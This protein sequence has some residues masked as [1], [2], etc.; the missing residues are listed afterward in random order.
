MLASSCDAS[1][2]S[3][4]SIRQLSI[5]PVQDM[6]LELAILVVASFAAKNYASLFQLYDG[7][8]EIRFARVLLYID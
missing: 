5:I 6:H 3:A 1:Q 7:L 2:I 8:I 4:G